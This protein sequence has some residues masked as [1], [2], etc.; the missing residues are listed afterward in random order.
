M[1]LVLVSAVFEEGANGGVG[2]VAAKAG[3]GTTADNG[4]AAGGN[5]SAENATG[6][7]NKADTLLSKA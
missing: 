1:L 4:S 2:E 3:A 6:E 7:K 5:G